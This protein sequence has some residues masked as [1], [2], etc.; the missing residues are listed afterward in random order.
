MGNGFSG[1]ARHMF[2]FST[3][4]PLALYI[5]IPWCTRKCPYCDFNSHEKKDELPE[6][7][8][9][10]ALIRDLEQ[11]LPRVW[12][13]RITSIF[14][15]GGTPSLF[16][17]ES[18]DTLLCAIRARLP[19]NPDIEI[20]LEA[21]PGS[22]EAEKF[23]EFRTVGVN[24]LSIGVQSFNDDRLQAIGRIHGR[25]E[26]IR[27]AEAA[28]A[29]GFDNFNLDIMFALPGQRIEQALADINTAID[30]QPTHISLYELTIEPNTLFHSQPP[31]LPADDDAWQMQEQCQARLAERGFQQYETSAYA[32]PGRQCR[33]NRNY[34]EFGDYLGIGAGAHAK[35]SAAQPQG[36]T[37]L[38]KLKQPHDYLAKIIG[39]ARIGGESVLSPQDAVLEF[40]INALRLTEGFAPGLFTAQTGLPFA[41]VEPPLLDAQ[42]RGLIERSAMAIRPTE[43]GKRLL[44]DLLQLF[45]PEPMGADR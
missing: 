26:A 34:W 43:T 24:R 25:R 8:Y 45:M 39:A 36:I 38:W 33:H 35:I 10:D 14:I 21:N 13:R 31:I 23:R 6:A 5:H 40:M 12:G 9:I 11:D 18:I 27:A 20:T 42:Q 19:F 2:N 3:L 28:H 22:S 30:L 41:M 29:A 17:A 37:R 7:A 1:L 32:K 16:S 4:P 15:G 44:N